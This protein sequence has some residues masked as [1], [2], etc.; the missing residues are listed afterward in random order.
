MQGG[1]K[2]VDLL[3]RIGRAHQ[4]FAD[5]ECVHAG[6]AQTCDV[7]AYADSR[8]ADKDARIVL[9]PLLQ[10]QRRV[11]GSLERAQIAVVDPDHWR[12]N[13]E[14]AFQFGFIV[15]LHQ[16]VQIEIGCEQCQLKQ[17]RIAQCCHDQQ[18]RIRVFPVDVYLD[19]ADPRL[20]P[21]MSATVIF[22]L[23]H[24]DDALA[25]PLDTVFSTA[26]AVRYVFVKKGETFEVRPVEVGIADTRR[27]QILNGLAVGDEVAR[28]RPLEFEGEIPVANPA[29]PP[30][31][32]TRTAKRNGG[33]D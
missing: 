25:V 9:H 19:E 2:R 27:V 12:R 10:A 5:Q 26:E 22:T 15:H 17:G 33:A 18:D 29:A 31:E 3:P 13:L 28:T 23:A 16:D 14:C 6:A 7:F 1:K 24:V 32:K 11:Q 8:L 20:R 4:R 30:P 21:G